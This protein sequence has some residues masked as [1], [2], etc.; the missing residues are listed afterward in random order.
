MLVLVALDNDI[1]IAEVEHEIGTRTYP[2]LPAV[3]DPIYLRGYI[4]LE[5]FGGVRT[6]ERFELI[7]LR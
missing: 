3:D 7:L 6:E 5:E 2:T 4:G 1:F